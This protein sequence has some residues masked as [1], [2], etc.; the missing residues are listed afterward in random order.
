VLIVGA[1]TMNGGDAALLLALQ[2]RLR[3][4]WGPDFELRVADALPA[5]SGERYPDFSFVPSIGVRAPRKRESRIAR[6]IRFRTRTHRFRFAAEL[7]RKRLRTWLR[8]IVPSGERQAFDQYHWADMVVMTGGTALV[9]HYPLTDRWIGLELASWHGKPLVLFTQ[10]LGPF[11]DPVNQHAMRRVAAAARRIF[12]RDERSL[13]HLEAIECDT[14]RTVVSTDAAFGLAAPANAERNSSR[15]GSVAISVR[16]WPYSEAVQGIDTGAQYRH[17]VARLAEHL[18][19]QHAADVTFVSTCQGDDRYWTDDSAEAEAI[20]A[21]IAPEVAKR[22][23]VDRS[24]RTPDSLMELLTSFDM[25]VATRMHMAILSLV[26]GRPVLPIAY[27]FKTEEVFAQLGAAHLTTPLAEIGA[28]LLE[29]A[30]HLIGA[31]ESERAALV[32]ATA[33]EKV[34][35]LEVV[36]ELRRAAR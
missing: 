23:N 20:R 17:W 5:A 16:S 22:V 21:T 36:A 25:V 28:P 33:I 27:E 1:V 11:T 8:F 35:A 3:D 30:D 34:R 18:V 31:L 2:A 6:S 19:E 29:R 13:R 9:E 15:V 4:A 10:S 14:S 32:A 12:L 24:F 26:S 7:R